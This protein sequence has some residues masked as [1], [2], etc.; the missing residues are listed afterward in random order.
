MN[1]LHT[2]MGSYT[3][4]VGHSPDQQASREG[5]P[6]FSL[7]PMRKHF[8]DAPFKLYPY[9]I[10]YYPML[11]M[12]RKYMTQDE[13]DRNILQTLND[14]LMTKRVGDE[15]TY[16]LSKTSSKDN[17]SSYFQTFDAEEFH[18]GKSSVESI[19]KI[20]SFYFDKTFQ[21]VSV[22]R[23]DSTS[24]PIIDPLLLNN[25]H[26]LRTS[27]IAKPF[28][29][30]Y[31]RLQEVVPEFSDL[32]GRHNL[33]IPDLK[34]DFINLLQL[35][36]LEQNNPIL[37]N[38]TP[39][40]L[41]GIDVVPKVSRTFTANTSI[42][43][44]FSDIKFPALLYHSAIEVDDKLILF[45]GLKPVYEY[46]TRISDIGDITIKCPC[47][48]PP[49][50]VKDIIENPLMIDSNDMY[51]FHVPSKTLTKQFM[52]GDIP[53]SL[54]G[55]QVNKLSDRYIFYYGGFEVVT[56]MYHDK[57]G[58]IIIERNCV[59]NS[60]GYIL[61]TMTFKFSSI[62]LKNM[63]KR[64]P[65][66]GRF[67]HLQ[68]STPNTEETSQGQKSASKKYDI[69]GK[70]CPLFQKDDTPDSNSRDDI[71][72]KNKDISNPI[73]LD[74]EVAH[75]IKV[76]NRNHKQTQAYSGIYS[77][78]IFGGYENNEDNTKFIATNSMWKIQIL[79]TGKGKSGY[80]SFASE[81][82]VY[83]IGGGDNILNW[84]SK[85]GFAGCCVPK[86]AAWETQNNQLNYLQH[87]RDDY[88][89]VLPKQ[90]RNYNRNPERKHSFD[91]YLN[92]I[93]NEAVVGADDIKA[94]KRKLLSHV[95]A[96]TPGNRLVMSGGSNGTDVCD[97]L[98]W[99]DM[100]K[101]IW[102]EVQLYGKTKDKAL[103]PITMGLVG[104]SMAAV[105]KVAVCV[106]GMT[107][108]DV[109]QLFLGAE[110]N[111][112][113]G[114]PPGSTFLNVFNLTNQCLSNSA[115]IYDKNHPSDTS[116]VV[117]ERQVTHKLIS[118]GAG[119]YSSGGSI[120]LTGGIMT[121]RSAIKDLRLA[122]CILELVT[123]LIAS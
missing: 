14:Y 41:R 38:I 62:Q 13:L 91:M 15:G 21:P 84:P 50:L 35:P 87:L 28:Y 33:W 32:L 2:L 1:G 95:Y 40:S 96:D 82:H 3:G 112:N 66:N 78:L 36:P 115:I 58:K 56:R 117:D 57:D 68:V 122:A 67:G 118:F 23:E 30:Y 45:G 22:D 19:G 80:Y 123:P 29:E 75:L 72:K 73:D 90:T 109:N 55:M 20:G 31:K 107:Q 39:L 86:K 27:E 89:I 111:K 11:D 60:V 42:T 94:T 47:E 74:S 49:P 101:K 105:S 64:H 99:Y 98:W 69:T 12:G 54:L 88:D 71:S 8:C 77:T 108:Q 17:S 113:K 52:K 51:I 120:F 81:A 24:N 9:M 48:L 92:T 102:T 25:L 70:Y 106:A 7:D 110:I 44:V 119:A 18:S 10:N 46:D 116:I 16:N 4:S 114:P 26:D 63:D 100:D 121:K 76:T 43:S 59:I 104:H 37:Q 65:L 5:S 79:V 34:P 93:S 97:D 6:S 83:W 61:D 53:P 85:R 103:E